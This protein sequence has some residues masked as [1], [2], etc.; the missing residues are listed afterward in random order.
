MNNIP[1]FFAYKP[2]VYKPSA[3]KPTFLAHSIFSALYLTY[4]HV[5]MNN[6]EDPLSSI[7]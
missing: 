7:P 4:E 2:Q 3:D 1:V 5:R 6:T